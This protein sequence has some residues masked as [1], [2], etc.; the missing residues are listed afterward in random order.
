MNTAELYDWELQHVHH[1]IDQDVGFY[2]SLARVLEG[3]VLELACGTGRIS[4]PLVKAGFDVV[5]LDIDPAMLHLARQR[6]VANVVQADM[7]RFAFTER[8]G[9]VAIPYNSLQLLGDDDGVLAC[10]RAAAEHVAPHGLLAF[11]VTDFPAQDDVDNELIAEDD[12]VRLTGS[13]RI[14]GSLLH[15]RRRFEADGD[16][17]E[18]VL[19]LRRDGATNSLRWIEAAGLT[20]VSADW[21]GLGLRVT[22]RP[23]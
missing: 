14:D 15:Y 12:G 3:P 16:V 11:E 7:R 1:R 17:Y 2:R 9:L 20:T 19:T 18:D 5:G 6:G 23:A 22:A 13:L 10:L 21:V 4:A 8:F